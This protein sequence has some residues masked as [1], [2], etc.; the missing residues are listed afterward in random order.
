MKRNTSRRRRAKTAQEVRDPNEL[1]R[2]I[3]HIVYEYANLVSSGTL[4]TMPLRPPCNSHVQ[5]A[6]LLGCRKLAEFFS[7]GGKEHDVKARHFFT[8]NAVPKLRLPE[9]KRWQEAMSQQLAHIT[10]NRVAGPKTWDGTRNPVL[11][12]EFRRAWKKFLEHLGEAHRAQFEREIA[13]RL[14]S[15]GFGHLDLK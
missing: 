4:L 9:W 10:Y 3:H 2:T 15:S 7:N 11:L 13:E 14:K 8:R 1:N 12:A 6:F 5:D